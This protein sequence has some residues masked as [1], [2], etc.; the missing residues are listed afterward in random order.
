MLEGEGR[1]G[2]RGLAVEPDAFEGGE[3]G[4]CSVYVFRCLWLHVSV[5]DNPMVEWG[6]SMALI[7]TCGG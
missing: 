5:S 3:C 6:M 1:P 2:I 7:R 4:E